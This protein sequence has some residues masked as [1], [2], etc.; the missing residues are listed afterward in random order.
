VENIKFAWLPTK[1]TSGKT[2]W[3]N[4]FYEHKALYDSSTGRP[5]L[6]G[7]YF[8]WSETAS[9]RTWRIL[10]ESAA[11]NRNVWNDPLLTKEDKL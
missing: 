3:L 7:L 11:Q 5:P 6:N 9:E 2:V 8:T 10:K 4:T 1:V